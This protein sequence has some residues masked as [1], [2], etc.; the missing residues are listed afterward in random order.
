MTITEPP[1]ADRVTDAFAPMLARVASAFAGVVDAPVWSLDDARLADRLA[2]ALR[3]KASA[4][5]LVA[6]LVAE[7]DDRDVATVS[8]ASSTQAHLQATYKMSRR[9][10]AT[11]LGQARAMTPRT[12]TTRAAFAA[13][14]LSA[15]QAVAVADAINRLSDDIDPSRIAAAQADLVA[16]APHLNPEQLRV[17]ANHLVEVVDPDG[18][19]A[20]LER[21]LSDQ[22]ARARQLTCF[23]MGRVG[24]GT[25][26]FSGRLP[27]CT[28]QS[29]PRLWTPTPHPD[30]V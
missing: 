28:Q 10:A 22:E 20:A 2:A 13:G 23:R 6:R 8:G 27:T 24:D 15:E 5:E 12:E 25:H 29:S 14:A 9:E 3:V 11:V 7:L 18:A 4:E 30:T 16:E 26:R 21:Q 19:D 1:T 17:V